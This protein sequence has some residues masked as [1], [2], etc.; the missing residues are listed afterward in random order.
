MEALDYFKH[1][2]KVGDRVIFP[3]GADQME[4]TVTKLG[5]PRHLYGINGM[6]ITEI[7]VKNDSGYTKTKKC[8]ACVNVTLIK[9]ALPEYQL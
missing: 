5:K 3:S 9:D 8:K 6:Q 4:G 2:I 1:P 7:L